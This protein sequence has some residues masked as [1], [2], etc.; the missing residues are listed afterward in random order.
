MYGTLCV[1][2]HSYENCLSF[3]GKPTSVRVNQGLE[4]KTSFGVWKPFIQVQWNHPEFGKENFKPGGTS[5][6]AKLLKKQTSPHT[7]NFTR[8]GQNLHAC[9]QPTS[10]V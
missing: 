8:F 1:P 3:P 10:P 5:C 2:K 9:A 6:I 4:N 7:L